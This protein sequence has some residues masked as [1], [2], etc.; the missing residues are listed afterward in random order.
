MIATYSEIDLDRI[1]SKVAAHDSSFD[2]D[3]E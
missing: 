2:K 3:R 1:Y